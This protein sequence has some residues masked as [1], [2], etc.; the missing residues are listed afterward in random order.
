MPDK[1]YD[2]TYNPMPR[3]LI[4]E[5]RRP[6]LSMLVATP[7]DDKVPA[8]C[9]CVIIKAGFRVRES[10]VLKPGALVLFKPSAGTLMP[11][12]EGHPERMVVPEYNGDE[13]GGDRDNFLGSL[14]EAGS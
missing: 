13:P 8:S 5:P 6:R 4:V 14:D 11:V 1:T 10:E 12:P 9:P 2:D 3:C 7:D